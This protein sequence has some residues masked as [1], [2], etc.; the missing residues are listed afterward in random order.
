M[1]GL[2]EVK[3]AG[4]GEE[5]SKV[6]GSGCRSTPHRPGT[7][8]TGEDGRRRPRVMGRLTFVMG[9][10]Q[11]PKQWL[12]PPCL[13]Q[14]PPEPG[15]KRGTLTSGSVKAAKENGRRTKSELSSGTGG[16]LQWGH[17]VRWPRFFHLTFL[18]SSG[19]YA[20]QPGRTPPCPPAQTHPHLLPPVTPEATGVTC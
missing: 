19:Q 18:S 6:Q 15:S 4:A 5:E 8:L 17:P 2:L 20:P 11:A 12:S 7:C 1:Q 13:R 16:Q 9:G 14:R 10:A 3:K